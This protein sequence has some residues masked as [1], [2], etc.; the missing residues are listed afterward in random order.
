MTDYSIRQIE[1][2]EEPGG[3]VEAF[4]MDDFRANHLQHQAV[5]LRGMRQMSLWHRGFLLPKW[6]GVHRIGATPSVKLSGLQGRSPGHNPSAN[7]C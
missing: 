3:P 1:S 7:V 4:C 5:R 2:S 6:F